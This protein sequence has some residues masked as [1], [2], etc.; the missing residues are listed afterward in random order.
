MENLSEVML[1]IFL[2]VSPNPVR[3]VSWGPLV[4]LLVIIFVL[5]VSFMAG[6]V[7]LLIRL[8]RRKADSP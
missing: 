4:L 3:V 5:A 7:F 1:M 8:K 6:L 2:D